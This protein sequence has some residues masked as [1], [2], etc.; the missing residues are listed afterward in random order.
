MATK[1]TNAGESS[2]SPDE[3]TVVAKKEE[4]SKYPAVRVLSG[5]E[6]DAYKNQKVDVEKAERFL[7]QKDKEEYWRNKKEQKRK[8]TET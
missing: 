3:L 7:A 8:K 4:K 2:S 5:A 6:L 1:Q